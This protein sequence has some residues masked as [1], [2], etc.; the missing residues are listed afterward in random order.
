M[1]T[2]HK[3]SVFFSKFLLL[4]FFS[5]QPF[6]AF[7]PSTDKSLHSINSRKLRDSDT[8]PFP[9]VPGKGGDD[10][11]ELLVIYNRV[12]KTG[13]TSFTGIAYDLCKGNNFNVLHVNT[14][15]SNHT[16]NDHVNS[17]YVMSVQDQVGV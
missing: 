13:S 6:L 15:K 10:S 9:M 8:S 11:Q 1:S 14:T 4:L 16:K 12:P 17:N 3:R 7:L 5:L 2:D